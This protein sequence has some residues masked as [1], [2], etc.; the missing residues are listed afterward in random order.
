MKSPRTAYNDPNKDFKN[1]PYADDCGGVHINSS[2]PNH[3][4]YLAATLIGGYAWEGAGPI[5]GKLRKNAGF[6]HFADATIENAG[7]HVDKIKE[8]WKLVGYP[9][10]TK[11][12]EL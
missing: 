2:I 11:R 8:A 10:S 4:F 1:L 9:F 5:Y 3:A 7:D 6:K 12:D